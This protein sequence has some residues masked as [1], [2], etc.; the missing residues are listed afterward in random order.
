MSQAQKFAA[1]EVGQ[2]LYAVGVDV[3]SKRTKAPSPYTEDE[4]M[5]DMLNAAK[6]G[7]TPAEKEILKPV[8]IGTSRTRSGIVK[9]LVAR[10]SLDRAKKGKVFQLTTTPQARDLLDRLPDV[11][12]SVSITALW[13]LALAQLADGKV[14]PDQLR[15]K[16][17]GMV[18]KLVEDALA[19]QSPTSGGA[20]NR[21]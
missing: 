13:E 16:V 2:V 8:G 18:K 10:G 11:M 21:R 15:Q 19:S 5:D 7:R 9:N 17:V 14:R 6:F 20:Q 1:Y 3:E 12:K 4:L